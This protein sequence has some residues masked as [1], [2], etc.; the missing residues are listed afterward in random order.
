M[1]DPASSEGIAVICL[2]ISLTA[3]L[4]GFIIMG[5]FFSLMVALAS[6]MVLFGFCIGCVVR[7]RWLEWKACCRFGTLSADGCAINEPSL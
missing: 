2:T 4:A 5:D 7:E 3:Y 6:L 1:E